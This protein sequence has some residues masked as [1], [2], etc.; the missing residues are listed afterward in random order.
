MSF[1]TSCLIRIFKMNNF[2]VGKLNNS[3]EN[4]E[5]VLKIISMLVDNPG[6]SLRAVSKKMGLSYSYV[7]RK[8]SSL[9]SKRI[10]S[11]GLMISSN[12]IGK[13]IAVIKINGDVPDDILDNLLKCNRVLIAFRSN[14]G[15]VQIILIGRKKQE[16]MEF[17][18]ALKTVI[19]EVKE[20]MIE[21]GVLHEKT[22]IP[23][24]NSHIKCN[25]PE[26][27]KDCLSSRITRYHG[28]MIH[29]Y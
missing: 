7:R 1:K 2:M 26:E 27:C 17:I 4:N 11:P 15:E 5:K 14:H 28:K 9:F 21:Y 20:I 8:T 10:I 19:N 6:V 12:M 23:L 3:I 16:I 24:K 22:M 13:E 29:Q 25:I 18:D